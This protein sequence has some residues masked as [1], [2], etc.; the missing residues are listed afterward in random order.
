MT[1]ESLGNRRFDT[2]NASY[3]HEP[4]GFYERFLAELGLEDELRVLIGAPLSFDVGHG[5]RRD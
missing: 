3:H 4:L 1:T 2:D 5:L